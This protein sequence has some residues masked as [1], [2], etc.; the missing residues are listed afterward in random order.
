LNNIENVYTG[1]L[2]GKETLEAFKGVRIFRRL[3]DIDLEQFEIDSI[4][5]D[6]PREGLDS[7]TLENIIEIKNIIYISC[8]FD[9]FKRD[10][11]ALKATHDILKLAMF[12][13][14]PYTE[15]IESGAI[16]RKKY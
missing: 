10:I 12:D 15:H 9:S 11:Q 7:F 2:S 8:G 16:L 3:K 14:F 13:Q 1:R 6:P 5:L 4:F